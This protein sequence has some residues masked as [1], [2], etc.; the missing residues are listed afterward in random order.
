MIKKLLLTAALLAPAL[1]YCQ[2][3]VPLNPLP[4]VAPP[5][6][7]PTVPAP[8]AAAGFTTL[9]LNADFSQPAYSNIATWVDGCGGPTSG[10]RWVYSYYSYIQGAPCGDLIMETDSSI[11][12]QV[13]HFQTHPGDTTPPGASYQA[14]VLA[15]PDHAF[16]ASAVNWIGSQMYMEITFRIDAASLAQS[17]GFVIG[18]GDLT[19]TNQPGNW[20]EPDIMEIHSNSN[21]GTGWVYGDGTIEWVNYAISNGLFSNPP[22]NLRLDMTAYHTI[23]TLFTSNTTDFAKCY[24]LDGTKLGC[25]SF[26]LTNPSILPKLDQIF[27]WGNGAPAQSN[28]VDTYIQSIN[29][30]MCANWKTQACVGTLIN[31]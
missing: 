2:L 26:T 18:G 4:P 23:G 22:G 17:T 31:Q 8:A 16:Q 13:L 29:I 6:Q 10:Y 5:A 11:G 15:W 12:K 7:D 24:Y 28:N 27:V 9:A 25:W 3:G 19:A 1:A 20:L 30:W 21:D 14:L